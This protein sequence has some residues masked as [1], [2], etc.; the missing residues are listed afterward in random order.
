MIVIFYSPEM[1][2]KGEAVRHLL[3]NV[4]DA[5]EVEVYRSLDGL[6]NRIIQPLDDVVLALVRPSAPADLEK[7]LEMKDRFEMLDVITIDSGE[8]VG[9]DKGIHELRPRFV[10]N[11]HDNPQVIE[12]V[13]K[14]MMER[15]KAIPSYCPAI[16]RRGEI[17]G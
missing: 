8:D 14:K 11:V 15:K 2:A 13:L 4:N 6:R 12:L 9:M 5:I 7:L 16:E 17:A 10:F 1:D 3:E